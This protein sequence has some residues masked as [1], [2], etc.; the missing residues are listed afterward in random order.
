MNP[1]DCDELGL[2]EGD[3]IE[4]Y[5]DLGACLAGLEISDAVAE[6][7]IELPTGA[8]YDPL[9]PAEANGLCVHG[10]PNV[11]TSDKGSSS[12]AQGAA[13]HS[14]LVNVRCFGGDLPPLTV[15][16]PPKLVNRAT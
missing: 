3:I 12:L 14:C 10:N 6:Q 7:I 2:E 5:N 1:K 8:W 9:D 13:A 15:D 4:V 16:R 11:L